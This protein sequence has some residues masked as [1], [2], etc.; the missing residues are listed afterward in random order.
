[1]ANV[2][3]VLGK[4]IC[5]YR[6]AADLSQ[7]EL[8]R[9]LG[10]SAGAVSQYESGKIDIP[11]SVQVRIAEELGVKPTDLLSNIPYQ[12]AF[13][14]PTEEEF[15]QAFIWRS[16]LSAEKKEIL[17]ALL[18]ATPTQWKGVMPG[19]STLL[20]GIATDQAKNSS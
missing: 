14:D 16:Q 7:K 3:E 1:M 2:L 15:V 19:L 5:D 10:I 13:R 12:P 18:R 17:S 8:G 6:E 9:R 11:F 20:E 4:K